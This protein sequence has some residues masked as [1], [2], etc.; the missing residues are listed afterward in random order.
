MTIA[1]LIILSKECLIIWGG[2]NL[3]GKLRTRNRV[4]LDNL[5]SIRTSVTYSDLD[6][7]T[8]L[9]MQNMPAHTLPGCPIYRKRNLNV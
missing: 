6:T 8:V 1:V 4:P 9:Q 7:Q 3:E 5:A 2:L